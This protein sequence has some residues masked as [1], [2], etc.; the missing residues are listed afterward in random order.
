MPQASRRQRGRI[1]QLPSGTWRP[2]VYAGVDPLTGKERRLKETAPTCAAAQVALTKL[3]RQVDE[4]NHPK[5]AITLGRAIEQ[6]LEVAEIQATTRERYEDLIRIYIAPAFGDM[7]ASKVDAELLERLYA[8]L[9]RCREL[10]S[11]RSSRAH[12][13]RPLSGSTVRKIH[14][15]INAALERAVRWRH[16]GM[17][18]AA[19]ALTPSAEQTEPDPPSAEETA[20]LLSEA[21][22]RPD[23]PGPRGVRR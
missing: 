22:R 3:Q 5:T 16:L 12:T 21:W 7:A 18:K 4:D 17:N 10:C 20:R 2:V 9:Q 8:P 23:H 1:E 19:L 6:W 15:I 14:F 11:G 13:C